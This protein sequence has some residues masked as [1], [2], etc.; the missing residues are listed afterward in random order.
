M[1]KNSKQSHRSPSL[2]QGFELP[3]PSLLYKDETPSLQ[4]GVDRIHPMP[5]VQVSA[6][7]HIF[8]TVVILHEI[9]HE[10]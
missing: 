4:S 1:S 2:V 3:V 9:N 6:G 5:D 10:L 7:I 8:T